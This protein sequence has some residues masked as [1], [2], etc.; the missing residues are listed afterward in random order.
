MPEIINNISIKLQRLDFFLY[1]IKET[2]LQLEKINFTKYHEQQLSFR[3]NTCI[4]SAN[5]HSGTDACQR[6]AG[7]K[8][9]RA[10]D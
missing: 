9:L 2:V 6:T 4:F 1:R 5:F 8:A 7:T 3:F 10:V